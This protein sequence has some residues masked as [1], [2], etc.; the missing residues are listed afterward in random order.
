MDPT[1][2]SLLRRRPG[3][4][5][6]MGPV[7]RL[8]RSRPP[9][10]SPRRLPAA[11]PRSNTVKRTDE[12]RAPVLPFHKLRRRVVPAL[13]RRGLSR[14]RPIL[15][16]RRPGVETHRRHAQSQNHLR[17]AARQPH[18]LGKASRALEERQRRQSPHPNGDRGAGGTGPDQRPDQP[19]NFP[20]CILPSRV[21]SRGF[22]KS[23][24]INL[25]LRPRTQD[26]L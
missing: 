23:D 10:P 20:R 9:P 18:S 3:Q 2:R 24:T 21:R 11:V 17:A 15:H 25:P 22:H 14:R 5:H 6:D 19:H 8:P 26:R 13:R 12:H 1:K 16:D 4:N 7:R